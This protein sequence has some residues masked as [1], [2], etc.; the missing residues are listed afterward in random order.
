[1]GTPLTKGS[2]MWL[3]RRDENDPTLNSNTRNSIRYYK[4]LYQAWPDWCSNHP[5]FRE[6]SSEWGRRVAAGEDVEID[7]IV[8][9]RSTLVCGLH[10]PWN[11][12][13]IPTSD[14][15]LKS[16]NWWP[17][18]PFENEELFSCELEPYQYSFF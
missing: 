3:S 7:H 17:D 15:Q 6:I 9:L 10:V 18:H 13:I 4:A 2:P 11:L 1:M 5:G 8:P 14:N 16:N 12:R